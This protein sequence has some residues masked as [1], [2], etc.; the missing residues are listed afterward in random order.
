MSWTKDVFSTM[1]SS[2]GWDDSTNEL[3]ITWAKSGKTSAYAGFDEAKALELA[4]APS[5]GQMINTEIKSSGKP[6][7]Y[8]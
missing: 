3:I 8:V 7:R 5:V 1:V 2:V 6:H 4:N